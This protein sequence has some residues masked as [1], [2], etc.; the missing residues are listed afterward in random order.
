MTPFLPTIAL[1]L[2]GLY[3]VHAFQRGKPATRSVWLAVLFTVLAM[4]DFVHTIIEFKTL[5]TFLGELLSYALS[6]AMFW[7]IWQGHQWARRTLI[8]AS[9]IILPFGFAIQG[10]SPFLQGMLVCGLLS[11]FY[12]FYYFFRPAVRHFYARTPV[13]TT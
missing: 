7:G 2:L 10:L 6:A 1:T 9:V 4:A 13:A 11:A 5:P 12:T 8:T 3:G